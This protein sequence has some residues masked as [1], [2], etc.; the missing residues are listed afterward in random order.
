MTEKKRIQFQNVR[1]MV[2]AKFQDDPSIIKNESLRFSADLGQ[3]LNR[4][5]LMSHAD[6]V[7]KWWDVVDAKLINSFVDSTEQL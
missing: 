6:K 2:T 1:M 3:D 7:Y 5:F 4:G